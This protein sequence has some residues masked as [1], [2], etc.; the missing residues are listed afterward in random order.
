MFYYIIL[1]ISIDVLLHF[2]KLKEIMLN[3]N[4]CI[5]FIRSPS[6]YLLKADKAFISLW[7]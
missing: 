4:I 1:T 6:P 2:V 7:L 5:E 3:T